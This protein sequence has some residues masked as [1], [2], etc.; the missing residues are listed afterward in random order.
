MYWRRML[1]FGNVGE[2]MH[3]FSPFQKPFDEIT[4][5]DLQVLK[6]TA[7]GWYVEYKQSQ[8]G[9]STIAKSISAFA[10]T[11]GGW[12]FYGVEENKEGKRTAGAFPG[13]PISEVPQYEEW[14]TQADALHVSPPAFFEHCVLRGPEPAIGLPVDRAVIMIHIP[15]GNDAPYVHSSGRIYRRVADS[16]DPTHE[17]DRHFLDLLWQ[18]G[19]DAR[20][21]F[22]SYLEKERPNSEEFDKG[23]AYLK[24]HFFADPWGDRDLRSNLTFTEARIL[25]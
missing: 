13:I 7:E 12:L 19:S 18:R 6:I 9:T 20:A 10:N 17:S 5:A 24:L 1:N 16:S 11:Y 25:W 15:A 21:R 2:S 22:R 23:C 14:I 4:A 3:S 8:S